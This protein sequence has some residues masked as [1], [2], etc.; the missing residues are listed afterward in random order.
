MEFDQKTSLQEEESGD[1]KKKA[2]AYLQF[3]RLKCESCDEK[4]LNNFINFI[5]STFWSKSISTVLLI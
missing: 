3:I 2:T 1:L 5:L 4:D